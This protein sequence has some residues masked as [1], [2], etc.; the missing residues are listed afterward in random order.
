MSLQGIRKELQEIKREHAPEF[1]TI[2]ELLNTS[3]EDIHTLSTH[4]LFRV[5]QYFNP[6]FET[7]ADLTT[8]V[9]EKMVKG[10]YP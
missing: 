6:E 3:K 1:K 8:E 7:E 2:E 4:D 9:L 5:I 10:E